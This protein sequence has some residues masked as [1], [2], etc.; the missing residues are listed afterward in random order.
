MLRTLSIRDFVT[1]S[2]LE[3]DLTDGFTVLTGETG[4]GKSILIDAMGLLLGDRADAIQIRAGAARADITGEFQVAG[5]LA[6]SVAESLEEAGLETV[7]GSI[8]VR[9]SIETGGRS[10]AWINGQVATLAQL[11]RLGEQLVNV[12]GQHA[13]QG[14]TRAGE[15]LQLLDRHAGL[16]EQAQLV[17]QAHGVLAKAESALEAASQQSAALAGV[18]EQLQ[19]RVDEIGSLGLSEG[20]WEAL[21]DEQ[22]RLAHGAEILQTVQAAL[23]ALEEGDEPLADSADRLAARIRQVSEKDDRLVPAADTLDTAGIALHEAATALARYL[24]RADLDPER[25]AQVEARLSAI[26]EMARKMKCRPEALLEVWQEASDELA[27]AQAAADIPALERQA[28]LA[29]AEYLKL[30]NALSSARRKAAA[31][32]SALV[33]GWLAELAMSGT[34][35][36]AAI[37]PREEPTPHGLEDVVFLFRH[38]SSGPAFPLS[39]IA[40]GGELSRVGLAIAAVAASATEIPTLLFDEVDAGIGGNTGHVIGRLLRELGGAHQVLAVTHLPQVAARAHHHLVVKK[41]V[42]DGVPTSEIQPLAQQDRAGEVARMLGDEGVQASS[43]EMAEELL[44]L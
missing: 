7:D 19:W 12:H 24:D 40:S 33:S 32:F 29:R 25:L 39:K 26:F 6:A 14:L 13:H 28:A 23:A 1:V 44:K 16:Q 3:L 31:E 18:R 37:E 20:E 10:R 11:K 27:A 4:A 35:F 38:Q 42:V 21:S 22:R 17:R 8:L 34:T 43:L 36:E 15:Q 9:R 5:P 2:A 30:A 41:S